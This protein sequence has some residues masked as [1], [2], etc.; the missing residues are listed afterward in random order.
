MCRAVPHGLVNPRLDRSFVII[1]GHHFVCTEGSAW[2]DYYFDERTEFFYVVDEA[3]CKRAA[4]ATG[5]EARRWCKAA[6]IFSAA[7]MKN[8][9]IVKL[10]DHMTGLRWRLGSY[11]NGC[12]IW[13]HRDDKFIGSEITDFVEEMA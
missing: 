11:R 6:S 3:G 1:D 9:D 13:T 12:F 7:P 5:D 8:A 10:H 2:L 4:L